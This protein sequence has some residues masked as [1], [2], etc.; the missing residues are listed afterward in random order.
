MNEIKY[1]EYGEIKKRVNKIQTENW[2]ELESKATVK[3]CSNNKK[4]IKD[5]SE[6]YNKDFRLVLLFRCRSNT[7]KL[8]Q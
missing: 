1:I 8:Q 6:I 3:I 2:G 7:L 4:E 5:E